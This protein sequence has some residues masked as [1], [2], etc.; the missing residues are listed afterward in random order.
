MSLHPQINMT[1]SLPS[2]DYSGKLSIGRSCLCFTR[3]SR[4][5]QATF[6][7]SETSPVLRIERRGGKVEQVSL[8]DAALCLKP[9]TSCPCSGIGD[10]KIVM[11]LPGGKKLLLKASSAE[12]REEWRVRLEAA[13]LLPLLK[14]K[15]ISA[16][17]LSAGEEKEEVSVDAKVSKVFREET[18]NEPERLPVVKPPEEEDE[19]V[20]KEER[21][22]KLG[23]HVQPIDVYA[24]SEGHTTWERVKED[25]EGS[26]L[27][28]EGAQ[29]AP[30]AALLSKNMSREV[31]SP[32]CEE[33]APLES[34]AITLSKDAE[35][36][37]GGAPSWMGLIRRGGVLEPD[38]MDFNYDEMFQE[39]AEMD[40]NIVPRR[41][42]LINSILRQLIQTMNPSK[43]P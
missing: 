3:W 11:K 10:Q 5:C 26:A 39:A 4:P 34:D 31:H 22:G 14:K 6:L 19:F 18:S 8:A 24:L 36:L 27:A 20:N 29:N 16:T 7:M 15:G 33:E 2:A 23:K 1:R 32:D 12:E 30:E 9:T 37:L 17:S 21:Q 25:A 35:E 41:S 42:A 28:S 43:V 38:M 40:E 13:M